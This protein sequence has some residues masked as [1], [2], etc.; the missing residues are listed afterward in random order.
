VR[1]KRWWGALRLSIQQEN[2]WHVSMSHWTWYVRC[3]FFTSATIAF[4]FEFSLWLLGDQI[5]F[6]LIY[7][8]HLHEKRTKFAMLVT[9]QPLCSASP[10]LSTFPPYAFQGTTEVLKMLRHSNSGDI[11]VKICHYLVTIECHRS[12][13]YYERDFWFCRLC[14]TVGHC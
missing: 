9:C 7:S 4:R 2:G 6:K 3:S 5:T 10:S 14:Q 1:S 13:E 12:N 8:C 11:V